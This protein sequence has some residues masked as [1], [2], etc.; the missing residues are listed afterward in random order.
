MAVIYTFNVQYY[1]SSG[2][3]YGTYEINFYDTNYGTEDTPVYYSSSPGLSGY[4]NAY[5]EDAYGDTLGMEILDDGSFLSYDDWHTH[6]VD[7]TGPLKAY[8][9]DYTGEGG[10]GDSPSSGI[11]QGV[12]TVTLVNENQEPIWNENVNI[13]SAGTEDTP[14]LVGTLTIPSQLLEQYSNWTQTSGYYYDSFNNGVLEFY[15]WDNTLYTEEIIIQGESGGGDYDPILVTI[16]YIDETGE[17]PTETDTVYWYPSD[18]YAS[19][20]AADWSGT[21]NSNGENFLRWQDKNGNYYDPGVS[22]Q[23]GNQDITLYAEWEGGDGN[24]W[25]VYIDLYDSDGTHLETRSYTVPANM[26]SIDFPHYSDGA[27]EVEYWSG[28]SQSY[29]PGDNILFSYDEETITLIAGGWIENESFEVTYYL[30]AEGTEI[31]TTDYAPN[32]P[33]Y[34]IITS[35]PTKNG[36]TFKEWDYP[37]N[38]EAWSPGATMR[39]SGDGNFYAVW[40]KDSSSLKAYIKEGGVWKAGS[41]LIKQGSWKSGNTFIKQEIWK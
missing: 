5:V 19:F 31:Y 20:T 37:S 35:I 29:Y 18:G 11:L 2:N 21:T 3:L 16:T 41:M 30:D 9:N 40:E 1:T 22:Y 23:I 17:Y 32:Y 27:R 15:T 4:T 12:A 36:Y 24:N 8:S 14:Y 34:T 10:G 7:A 28:D 38:G 25:T 33:D 13:Y 39:L 26:P 6:L